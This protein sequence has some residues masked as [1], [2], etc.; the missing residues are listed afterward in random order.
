MGHPLRW[1]LPDVIYETTIRTVQERFLLRPTPACR[2][3][4]LGVIGR[5]Q[6]LYPTVRLYAFVFLSNHSHML[7]SADDGGTLA[8]FIGYVNGNI[9]REM[10]R[11]HDWS[12]PVWGRRYRPI[13]VL[14]DDA[15]LA[16]LRYVLGQGVKEGL[17]ASPRD[18]PGATAVPALL[19]N[20]QLEGT[21]FDRDRITRDRR[22]GIDDPGAHAYRYPV[23]LAPIPHWVQLSSEQLRAKY[24]ELVSQAEREATCDRPPLGAAALQKQSPFARPERP[25][26]SP[27]PPCHTSSATLRQRFVSAFRAFVDS[28]RAAA[29]AL[30]VTARVV[31]RGFPP[32]SFP[33]RL[34]H[35]PLRSA[36]DAPWMSELDLGAA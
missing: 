7:L 13:P 26:R 10:G 17:V 3:A 9:A 23:R 27:A 25:K 24:V 16:R 5:A 18:W 32:G 21:W 2:D 4:I 20:M 29:A 36:C 35:V 11:I 34:G 30:C 22:R 28:F 14:D 19:G 8:A 33:P 6:A 15:L 12:G 1:F 31:A